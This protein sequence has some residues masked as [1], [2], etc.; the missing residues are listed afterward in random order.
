MIAWSSD[1]TKFVL[2]SRSFSFIGFSRYPRREIENDVYNANSYTFEACFDKDVG[3]FG[4][5]AV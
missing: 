3:G 4:P 5:K 1:L 2:Y